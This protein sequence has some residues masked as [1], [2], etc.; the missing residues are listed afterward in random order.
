[1][2]SNLVGPLQAV[3]EASQGKHE[4][5]DVARKDPEEQDDSGVVKTAP[6]HIFEASAKTDPSVG[7]PRYMVLL[8]PLTVNVVLDID[9]PH[10]LHISGSV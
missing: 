7:A 10:E 6:R 1:M 3:H 8:T 4:P 5:I 9:R 2:Q